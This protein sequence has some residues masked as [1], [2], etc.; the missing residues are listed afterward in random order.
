[1]ILLIIMA[2]IEGGRT[3][4]S[5]V[6]SHERKKQHQDLNPRSILHIIKHRDSLFPDTSRGRCNKNRVRMC[7]SLFLLLYTFPLKYPKNLWY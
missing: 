2:V 7:S 5:M 3:S 6:G 4:W 1:M